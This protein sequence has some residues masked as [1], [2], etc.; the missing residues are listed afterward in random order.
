MNFFTW[1]YYIKMHA[2]DFF[3]LIGSK[4][5][6]CGK[7]GTEIFYNKKQARDIICCDICYDEQIEMIFGRGDNYGEE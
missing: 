7:K 2:I 5:A 3:R 6:Y 1:F 4:C